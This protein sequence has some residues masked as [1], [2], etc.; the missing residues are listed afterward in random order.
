MPGRCAGHGFEPGHRDRRVPRCRAHGPHERDRLAGHAGVVD[1]GRGH[2]RHELQRIQ[3][4]P[5]R[6]GAAPGAARDHPHLRHRRPLRR[7]RPLLRGRPE[8]ARPDRLPHVHDRDERAAAGS[9][10]LRTRMATGVGAARGRDRAVDHHLA[11]A[12]AA[13][14]LLGRGVAANRLRL[15]RG[16]HDDRRGVGRRLPQQLVPHVRG[17][18]VPQAADLRPVGARRDRHVAAG[19]QPR[20]DPRAPAV[21]GPLAQGHR[22]R[23]GRRAAHRPVRPAVDAAVTRPGHDERGVAVRAGLAAATPRGDADRPRERTGEPPRR[24]TRHARRPR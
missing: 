7:R 2:V 9:I 22:Q 14:R 5:A 20:P 4:D 16:A 11:R 24:G 6:D 23:R 19:P 13:R 17:A 3:L 15:D 8:A 21:V 12:S 10:G 1:G 18:E